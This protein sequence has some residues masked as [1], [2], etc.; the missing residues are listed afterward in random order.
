M[1]AG[2]CGYVLCW[3]NCR[4]VLGNRRSFFLVFAEGFLDVSNPGN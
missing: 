2:L 3:V 4:A 1:D